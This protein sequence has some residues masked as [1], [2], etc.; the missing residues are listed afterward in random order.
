VICG[1][2]IEATAGAVTVGV[3]TFP[4]PSGIEQ[5]VCDNRP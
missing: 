3:N 4:D 5:D 2:R 1:I